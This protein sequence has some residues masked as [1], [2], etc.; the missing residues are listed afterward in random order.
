MILAED[1]SSNKVHEIPW[2][3][4]LKLQAVN[5]E[6][7]DKD[8]LVRCLPWAKTKSSCFK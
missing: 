1:L 5:D 8:E 7:F 2:V 6:F 4:M 3:W